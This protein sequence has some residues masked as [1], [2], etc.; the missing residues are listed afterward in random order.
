M[1]SDGDKV[2]QM[3]ESVKNLSIESSEGGEVQ[4]THEEAKKVVLRSSDDVVFEVEQSVLVEAETIAHM[5]EEGCADDVIPVANVTGSILAMVIEYCKMHAG[6]SDKNDEELK[7][8]DKEFI[9]RGDLDNLYWILL[10]ANFLSV[11]GLLDLAAQRV[12]DTIKGKTPEQ[13]RE[14]FNITNDFTP[15]EEAAI[16]REHA[17][18]FE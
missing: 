3:E 16:R 2:S 15:E 9:Y 18:A 5:I 7:T 13:I 4:E 10:G 6:K 14:I 12:A 1:S 17:W 8:W 11:K